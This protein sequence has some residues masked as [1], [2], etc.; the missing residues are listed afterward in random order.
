MNPSKFRINAKSVFLTYPKC[1]LSKEQLMN[2]LNELKHKYSYTICCI[3]QHKDGTPHLHCV[4]KFIKKVDIR[5]ECYFDINGYH[6]NIQ[7]TKNINASINYIKKDG[8]YLES[9][10]LEEHINSQCS[11]MVIPDYTDVTYKFL[12]SLLIGYE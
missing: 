4:L 3:E 5:S 6:P 11:N 12:E 9:G 10:S 7:T 8:N 1:L 2:A